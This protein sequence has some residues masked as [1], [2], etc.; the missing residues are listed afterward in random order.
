MNCVISDNEEKQ[1]ELDGLNK[2]VGVRVRDLQ[3]QVI[4]KKNEVCVLKLVT[5]NF[6]NL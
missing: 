5:V 6:V 3:S 2:L 4:D 1:V